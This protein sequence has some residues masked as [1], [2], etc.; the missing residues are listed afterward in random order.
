MYLLIDSESPSLS[1]SV[2]TFTMYLDPNHYKGKHTFV[3]SVVIWCMCYGLMYCMYC[4]CLCICVYAGCRVSG[5][6]SCVCMYVWPY[7]CMYVC[8]TLIW[9]V[10]YMAHCNIFPLC[11]YVCILVCMYICTVCMYAVPCQQDL[12]LCMLSLFSCAEFR[13]SPIRGLCALYGLRLER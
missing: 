10:N 12:R 2:V 4:A 13:S 6:F 1:S 3:F 8:I 9:D 5:F 7:V 11:M